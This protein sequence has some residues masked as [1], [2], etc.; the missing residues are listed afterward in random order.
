MRA[1]QANLEMRTQ[2]LDRSLSKY[3]QGGKE[4][5]QIVQ[6]YLRTHLAILSCE[7]EINELKAAKGRR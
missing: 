2:S 1:I 7:E 6:D 5:E 4:F 3:H